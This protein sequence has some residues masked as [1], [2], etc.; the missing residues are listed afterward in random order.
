MEIS[1]M[2]PFVE[3]STGQLKS[4]EIAGEVRDILLGEN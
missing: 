1:R 3:V 2:N 4:L